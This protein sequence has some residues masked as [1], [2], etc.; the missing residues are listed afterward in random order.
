[1][2][3]HGKLSL[4]EAYNLPVGLR[5]WFLKRLQREFEEDKERHEAASRRANSSGR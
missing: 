1:M 5:A 3:F 4:I 2:V